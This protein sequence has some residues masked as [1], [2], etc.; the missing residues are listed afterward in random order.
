MNKQAK[1]APPYHKTWA[2]IDL[3]ALRH[4]YHLL[5]DFI[6]SHSP[7]CDIMCVVK[8]DAY[9]HSA[10]DCVRTLL[11]CGAKSFA[12]SC[13]EEA[14][15]VYDLIAKSGKSGISLLILGYTVPSKTHIK[16][17]VDYDI[18][19]TVY[20]YEYAKELSHA[21]SAAAESGEISKDAQLKVHIK[22]DTGMN[23]LGFPAAKAKQSKTVSEICSTVSLPHIKADGIFTHF[24]CSD[25]PQ[26]PMTKQQFALYL[27]VL[28]RLEGQG[29]TFAQ[30]HA[31]NS[32]AALA[33]P[34]MHLDFVRIGLLLYGLM[35]TNNTTRAI[36]NSSKIRPVM[37]F[38][39]TVSHI[40]TLETGDKVSYGANFCAP[41][42]MRVA[43]LSVGYA[44]GYIRAFSH[45]GGVLIGGRFA[46][47]IG[48]ICMD[49]SVVDIT[50]ID[51]SVGDT[52]VIF[53]SNAINTEHLAAAAQTINYEL[54]C[55]VGKR[56]PR[57]IINNPNEKE[58]EF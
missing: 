35:P 23:R 13:I 26:D 14:Q 49:Q 36:F 33:F 7:K 47:V 3:A 45:G 40:H 53:D 37:S 20:S 16:K 6:H 52:A 55:L 56:V 54:V 44:D 34:E 18:T 50:D 1:K 27:E 38:M 9:G 39:T 28:D 46:P 5:S 17:L 48:R 32:A 24:A 58:G 51:V 30:K 15:Q 42:R 2:E 43:T 8:A 22:I 11:D 57:V 4:N 31:C 10:E 29:V 21:L 41:R 12:V 19:Q 25:L